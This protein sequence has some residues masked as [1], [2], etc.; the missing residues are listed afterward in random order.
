MASYAKL[1]LCWWPLHKKYR[2]HF[3]IIA[4]MLEAVKSN[5]ASLSYLWKHTN[6]NCAQLKKYLG[7]LTE[8]GFINMSIVRGQV[9]YRANEK[10]M[11]FLRQYHL[12]LSMLLGGART[13]PT[14]FAD[15]AKYDLSDGRQPASPILA[16]RLVQRR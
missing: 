14:S 12:L 4:S 1:D 11:E 13:G 16:A 3:E 6:S 15:E 2:S 5:E 9:L 10:G 8:R 7:W